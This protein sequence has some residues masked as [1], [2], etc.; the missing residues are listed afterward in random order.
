MSAYLNDY[1]DD[2]RKTVTEVCSSCNNEVTMVWNVEQNGY[3]ATCPYCGG[4]LMLCHECQHPGG[5]CEC[6]DDCDYDGESDTCRFNHEPAT[7]KMTLA[8]KDMA[9]TCKSRLQKAAQLKSLSACPGC[10][11]GPICSIWVGVNPPNVWKFKED[12]TNG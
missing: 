9:E 5:E 1:P 4:S 2:D 10:P 12:K 3:K 7:H 8:L 11:Y 6:A